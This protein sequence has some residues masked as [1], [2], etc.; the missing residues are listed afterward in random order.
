MTDARLLPFLRAL[1]ELLAR[2]VV[3][4][5]VDEAFAESEIARYS[6]MFSDASKHSKLV[7]NVTKLFREHLERRRSE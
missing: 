3:L 1:A 2:R 6:A 7:E 5:D 4:G